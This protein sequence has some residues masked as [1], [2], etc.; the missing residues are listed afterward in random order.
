[1]RFTMFAAAFLVAVMLQ[2]SASAQIVSYTQD[3]DA[4][5]PSGTVLSDEG[6]EFYSDNGGLGD[7][8]GPAPG[9]G[10]Q[11]SALADDGAGN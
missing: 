3:F 6:W 10:P 5:T 7:Y 11:I 2:S 8:N 1:M 4:L 9:E